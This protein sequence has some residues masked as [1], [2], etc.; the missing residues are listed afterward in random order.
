MQVTPI[1]TGS[2]LARGSLHTYCQAHT[3]SGPLSNILRVRG[4][5]CEWGVYWDPE[6]PPV[7]PGRPTGTSRLPGCLFTSLVRLELLVLGVG[8]EPLC[9]E[10]MLV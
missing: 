1:D 10:E 3:W 5:W 6:G 9:Q 8:G 7:V 2:H 4:N